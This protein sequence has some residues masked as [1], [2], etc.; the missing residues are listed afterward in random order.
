MYAGVTNH[1][2]ILLSDSFCDSGVHLPSVFD[3]GGCFVSS[4]E[5][6]IRIGGLLK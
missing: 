1:Q 5:L 3:V 6:Q 2:G 4:G